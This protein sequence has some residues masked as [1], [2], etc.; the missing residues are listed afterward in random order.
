MVEARTTRADKKA[1]ESVALLDSARGVADEAAHKVT[2][3]E[4]ELLAARQ[5]RDTVEVKLL[6]FV[7][8]AATTDR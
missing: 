4:G 6:G 1:W 5:A 8:R 7:N 3:I 2:L